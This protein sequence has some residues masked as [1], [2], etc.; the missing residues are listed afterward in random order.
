MENLAKEIR[1][2]LAAYLAGDLQAEDFRGWFASA[3][4]DVHKSNDPEAEEL[5]HA[6]EW[7]FCDFERGVSSEEI[8]QNLSRLAGISSARHPLHQLPRHVGSQD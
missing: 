5:A 6:V 8:R 7:E 1:E 2:H 3:L 4:R